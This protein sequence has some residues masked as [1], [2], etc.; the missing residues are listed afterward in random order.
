MTGQND[1]KNDRSVRQVTLSWIVVV[2]KT[3]VY[4]SL[5]GQTYYISKYEVSVVS[6]LILGGDVQ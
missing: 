1:N 6:R 5:I 4:R 2:N 3:G